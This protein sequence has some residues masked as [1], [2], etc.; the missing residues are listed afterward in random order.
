MRLTSIP[1]IKRIDL[2]RKR[3]Q[4]RRVLSACKR[5]FEMIGGPLQ[6]GGV[7]VLPW[8]VAFQHAGLEWLLRHRK[9]M[10]GSMNTHDFLKKHIDQA[11][12]AE[13]I[14]ASIAY[15]TTEDAL[16]YYR[17]TATFKGGAAADCLRY[18]RERAKKIA[19]LNGS[20]KRA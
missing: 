12:Q 16:A 3:F 11:L 6:G 17:R 15:Q 14:K 18:A 8:N 7:V 2:R 9:Q 4:R 13:G 5:H 10:G 19:A 20:K 1:R